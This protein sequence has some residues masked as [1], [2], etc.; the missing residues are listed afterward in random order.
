LQFRI[1]ESAIRTPFVSIH[2][3][4]FFRFV[5]RIFPVS[6]FVQQDR[7]FRDKNEKDVN[8]AGQGLPLTGLRKPQ[9]ADTARQE[10]NLPYH[11]PTPFEPNHLS[12]QWKQ[13]N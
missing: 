5:L 1:A 13:F 6:I 4:R 11:S 7:K 9:L 10:T 8:F 2:S 3:V 12:I